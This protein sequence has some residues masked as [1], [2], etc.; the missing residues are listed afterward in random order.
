MSS[1]GFWPGGD[2]LPYP[3]FYSYAYPEPAGFK[4]ATVRP[5][6]VRYDSTFGEF[7]LP[8]DA[9]RQAGD[10]EAMLLEFLQ[11]SYEAAADLAGWDREALEREDDLADGAR[12]LV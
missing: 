4:S 12:N 3:V 5:A 6:S 8:Y 2:A 1:C 7:V 11:S 10:G 9:V